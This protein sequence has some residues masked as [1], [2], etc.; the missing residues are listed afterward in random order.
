MLYTPYSYS[1][2]PGPHRLILRERPVTA[3]E[4]A[5]SAACAAPTRRKRQKSHR[6][7]AVQALPSIRQ[8]IISEAPY[9]A[10]YMREQNAGHLR[11]I[12]GMID[13]AAQ[14]ACRTCQMGP[15]TVSWRKVEYWG[16]VNRHIVQLPYLRCEHIQCELPAAAIG[17]FGNAPESPTVIY[18]A[19]LLRYFRHCWHSGM[20]AAKFCST[21]S[22]S[23]E[24]RERERG[25]E[26]SGATLD[27]STL[28]E[29]YRHWNAVQIRTPDAVGTQDYSPGRF[30]DCGACAKVPSFNDQGILATMRRADEVL[31]KAGREIA[32][33]IKRAQEGV[34]ADGRSPSPS[35]VLPE[36]GTTV[37]AKGAVH[38]NEAE[39]RANPPQPFF[40]GAWANGVGGT[41]AADARSANAAAAE[42]PSG[43]MAGTDGYGGADEA[44]AAASAAEA[45]SGADIV[46]G[47]VGA[48]DGDAQGGTGPTVD[49]AET[50]NLRP[51]GITADGCQKVNRYASCGRAMGNVAV[52]RHR[53]YLGDCHDAVD[54]TLTSLGRPT[55]QPETECGASLA[56]ARPY[57]TKSGGVTDIKCLI[58]CTCLH[59]V[60][61]KG[62]FMGVKTH[63]HFAFY[64]LL[65]S[66]FIPDRL[67]SFAEMLG[68]PPEGHGLDCQLKYK[69]MFA[70]GLGRAIGEN[71]EQLHAFLKPLAKSLRYM[72]LPN[73]HD[74]LDDA[75][76][77]FALRKFRGFAEGLVKHAEDVRKRHEELL[78]D[79]ELIK[80]KASAMNVILDSAAVLSVARPAA[81][82]DDRM[83]YARLIMEKDFLDTFAGANGAYLAAVSGAVGKEI[84]ARLQNR[85]SRDKVLQRLSS[86]QSKLG[87]WRGRWT[88][89]ISRCTSSGSV[90]HKSFIFKLK[91]TGS[92]PYCGCTAR[93]GPMKELPA[94]PVVLS[95]KGSMLAARGFATS[96]ST[97]SSG[98][99]GGPLMHPCQ[100]TP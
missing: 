9:I 56:C 19:D 94:T 74:F 80:A 26:Q 97:G 81:L 60:P 58:T 35:D 63:E 72:A 24:D 37:T 23:Q 14:G 66:C 99:S 5:R 69:A 59:T 70:E 57:A 11:Q 65:L 20:S 13:F 46:G 3:S 73:W 2:S 39:A 82:F 78:K 41:V 77:V 18:E 15:E 100:N 52:P 76:G 86:L 91:W 31:E 1:A 6:H 67:A 45:R 30:G 88:A 64:D 27:D 32:A 10:G 34:E 89:R 42:G 51:M 12:R 47:S 84:I 22:C 95:P 38:P 54:A 61:G 83:E 21:I 90:M 75:I 71:A 16:L 4:A 29:T 49:P 87:M 40:G 53:V 25:E 79:I 8:T 55:M 17:C 96:C 44:D 85:D 92:C 7:G 43:G 48:A 98:R 28:L 50:P 33:V 62:C 93:T 68:I 36:N